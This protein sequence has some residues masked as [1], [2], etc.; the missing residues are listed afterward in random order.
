[1][2]EEEELRM[3][4]REVQLFGTRAGTRT[5]D[6]LITGVKMRGEAAIREWQQRNGKTPNRKTTR[7]K[8][9]SSNRTGGIACSFTLTS[10]LLVRLSTCD[11]PPYCSELV[12]RGVSRRTMVDVVVSGV[13]SVLLQQRKGESMA[14]TNILLRW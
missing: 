6:W 7:R 10:D 9:G 3:E 1:M 2:I 14:A 12:W 11:I 4:M 8:G 5:T 13:D